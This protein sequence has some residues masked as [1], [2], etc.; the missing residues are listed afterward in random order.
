VV[1]VTFQNGALFQVDAA[2]PH[3]LGAAGTVSAS[4][5]FDATG[6]EVVDVI[7]QDGTLRQFDSSGVHVLGAF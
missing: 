6:A 4:V 2:G 3:L 7:S 1:L 5:A